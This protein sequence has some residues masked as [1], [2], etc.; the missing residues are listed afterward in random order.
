MAKKIS[1]TEKKLK[2]LSAFEN[3]PVTPEHLKSLK[4]AVEGADN[5]VAA[6][7]ARIV[8]KLEITEL[9]GPLADA[10]YRFLKDPVKKD[11]GCIAKEAIAEALD[12]VGY[13]DGDLFSFGAKYVQLEPSYIRP[14]DAAAALRGRCAFAMARLGHPDLFPRLADL[15]ADSEIQPRAAAVELLKQCPDERAELLL[16]LKIRLGDEDEKIH[17]DCFSALMAVSPVRSMELMREFL[18]NESGATAENAAY[19]LGESKRTDAFEIL[20]RCRENNIN[21]AFQDMLVLPIA[22]NRTEESFRYLMEI[23]EREPDY[24][25]VATIKALEIYAG[26]KTRRE[27]IRDAVVNRNLKKTVAAFEEIFGDSSLSPDLGPKRPA[28]N[29][30]F[31]IRH[32]SPT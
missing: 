14:T 16:R 13:D 7:A 18:E 9:A 2:E 3:G 31:I 6:K 27:R 26:D 19:A 15:L 10:F 25:G 23:I 28:K 1:A 21:P 22:L 17:A 20:K 11:K 12:A 24:A 29:P 8:G 32:G 4:K 30:R 5:I